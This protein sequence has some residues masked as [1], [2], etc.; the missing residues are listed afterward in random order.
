M[1]SLSILFVIIKHKRETQKCKQKGT[2]TRGARARSRARLVGAD[3]FLFA[4][5]RGCDCSRP[6]P[7]APVS[8]K[9]TRPGPSSIPAERHPI[10]PCLTSTLRA[11]LCPVLA[12]CP[13][14][15]ATSRRIYERRG[16]ACRSARRRLACCL[17]GASRRTGTRRPASDSSRD[18]TSRTRRRGRFLTAAPPLAR[19]HTVRQRRC[20][21]G[22]SGVGRM[23]RDLGRIA[24]STRGSPP[25]PPSLPRQHAR[26]RARA[27]SHV[28][29]WSCSGAVAVLQR[30]RTERARRRHV[31]G[32]PSEAARSRPAAAP[33][34]PL[35]RPAPLQCET[36]AR[37]MLLLRSAVDMQ[38]FLAWPCS[39]HL[40]LVSRVCSPRSPLSLL[41][42]VPLPRPVP[43]PG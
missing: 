40:L 37:G 42:Q 19:P 39:T 11:C 29:E 33:P 24:R 23:A 22:R 3:F 38:Q 8:A 43:L 2:P 20:R 13:A 30:G 41:P 17:R 6:R 4:P 14:P 9:C 32:P 28:G 26:R 5:L 10:R 15:A 12:R 35:S 1:S 27:C 18:R 36:A 16:T 21:L 31:A 7:H 25:A 34:A